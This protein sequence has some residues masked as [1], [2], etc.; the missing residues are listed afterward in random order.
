MICADSSSFIAF[1]QG[2]SEG[3]V[4]LVAE[5]LSGGLLVLAPVSITE[6]LSDPCLSVPMQENLISIPTLEVTAGY[7]ERAGKLRALLIG[8]Q[9]RA[10]SADTLI[11]QSCIDHDVPLVTRDRDFLGFQ[12]LAGLRLLT[13]PSQVQ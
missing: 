3:D 8:H 10:K 1:I 12:K 7:W 2:K 13:G 11:A 5:A 9:Y 6:L 4:A